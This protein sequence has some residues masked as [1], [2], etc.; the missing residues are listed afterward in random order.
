[1]KI[2]SKQNKATPGWGYWGSYGDIGMGFSSG[3]I[4]KDEDYAGEQVHYHKEATTYILVL[5]GSGL[6]EVNGQK[7]TVVQDELLEIAPEEHYRMLGGEDLPFRWITISSNK[8][9]DDKVAI[10]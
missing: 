9:P 7:V 3:L 8:N 1:M 10:S 2:H 4:S 5:E 6:V